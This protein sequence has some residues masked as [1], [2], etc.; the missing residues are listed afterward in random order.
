MNLEKPCNHVGEDSGSARESVDSRT[1]Q[2]RIIEQ[3]ED[4]KG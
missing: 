1:G 2:D 3:Q 4:S